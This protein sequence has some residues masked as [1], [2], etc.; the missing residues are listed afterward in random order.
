M[1]AQQ[2]G[3]REILL[4]VATI[5][6]VG[7]FLFGAE[8]GELGFGVWGLGFLRQRRC[9]AQPRVALRAPWGRN[10]STQHL[11]VAVATTPKPKAQTLLSHCGVFAFRLM[12]H[13]RGAP[14]PAYNPTF[15]DGACPVIPVCSPAPSSIASSSCPSDSAAEAAMYD[16]FL[17]TWTNVNP[18]MT[19]E[20]FL[21]KYLQ[22]KP[23]KAD[24]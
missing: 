3:S 5:F 11:R 10:T 8:L 14:P 24:V 13:C 9:I 15:E 1:R 2:S 18:K 4:W 16:K 7:E 12:T 20:P 22:F 17:S 19:M 21:T 23:F 6:D